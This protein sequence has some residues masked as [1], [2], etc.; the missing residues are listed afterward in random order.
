MHIFFIYIVPVITRMDLP[1]GNAF[2]VGADIAI[3]CEIEGYP[4]PNVSWFKDDNEIVPSNRIQIS[5]KIYLSIVVVGIVTCINYFHAS[6]THLI[7]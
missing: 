4:T 7:L 3:H 2:A 5:G 1:Q 6:V